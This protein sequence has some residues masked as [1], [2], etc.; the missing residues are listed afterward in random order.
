MA[1]RPQQESVEKLG[2]TGQEG[3]GSVRSH[4]WNWQ[5][6]GGA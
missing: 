4:I 5:G 3:H 6:G 1:V 2:F